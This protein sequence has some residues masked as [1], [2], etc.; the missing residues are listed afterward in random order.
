MLELQ[1]VAAAVQM[2]GDSVAQGGRSS[3]GTSANHV[4]RAR[5]ARLLGLSEER[6]PA[7]REIDP[8]AIRSQ[9]Q[10]PSLAAW[11]ANAYRSSLRD[12]ALAR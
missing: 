11:M 9:S 1:V 12:R 2:S 7:R 3:G 10:I 4:P 6:T 8:I 5:L